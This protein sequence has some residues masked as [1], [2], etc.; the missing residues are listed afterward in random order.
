MSYTTMFVVKNNGEVLPLS[1]FSNS[2]GSAAMVWTALCEKYNVRDKYG[3]TSFDAWQDLWKLE[4]EKT[5][6]LEQFE[7]NVLFS[8]Y[9]NAMVAS[10]DFLKFADSLRKFQEVHA[11][12]K[13]V[14]HLSAFADKIEKIK[15]DYIG[16]CFWQTSVAD[17]PWSEYDGKTDEFFPY[18]TNT[19][20]KH[21]F[22]EVL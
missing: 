3:Y 5:V 14:C 20:T 4:Q 16:V 13:Q 12:P 9:D 22:I 1:E 6:K 8:T 7:R 15:D 19:G 21:W 18:N 2:W 17:N 10:K 11:K